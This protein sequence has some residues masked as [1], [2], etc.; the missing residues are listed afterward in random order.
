MESQ[1][2]TQSELFAEP[3]TQLTTAPSISSGVLQQVAFRGYLAKGIHLLRRNLFL[4]IG[5][6]IACV[7]I[8]AGAV[9]LFPNSLS[10]GLQLGATVCSPLLLFAQMRLIFI[11][12]P[13]LRA[14]SQFRAR[15][16]LSALVPMVI[17]P[18]VF[19]YATFWTWMAVP[20][21]GGLMYTFYAWGIGDMFVAG[22]LDLFV[23]AIVVGPV[24]FCI[25]SGLFFA[26]LCAMLDG[27]GPVDAIRRGWRMAG[28][29]RI[30]ILGLT[31]VCFSLP[32]LLFLGAYLLS[33]LQTGGAT[34]R[35]VPAIL[36][37]VS[38]AIIALFSGPWFT[39]AMAA[40]F[41]PLKQEE[42]AYQLRRAERKT[43]SGFS[44]SGS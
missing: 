1:I 42:D 38:A 5:N 26:P 21:S 10:L 39:G 23:S 2:G 34:F 14:S 7:C 12:V 8:M 31:A 16:W 18:A 28:S 33:I 41:V 3:L 40:L 20:L 32:M 25:A 15:S 36:W 19:R 13:E 4:L 37:S 9:S 24:G 11:L 35:G 44:I 43:S 27:K 6:W 29:Q 22:R 17:T 30:K